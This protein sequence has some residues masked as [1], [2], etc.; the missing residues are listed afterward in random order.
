RNNLATKYAGGLH[1]G[2]GGADATLVRCRFVGN[3]S[4]G[5]AGGLFVLS[6]HAT[7]INSTFEGNTSFGAGALWSDLSTVTCTNC[8]FSGNAAVSGGGIALHHDDNLM[9]LTNC[10]FSRNTASDAG[11]GLLLQSGGPGGPSTVHFINSILWGNQDSGGTDESAQVLPASGS[12]TFDRTIVQGWTG[13]YGGTGN[14]GANP[15]FVDPDGADDVVGTDDDDLRLQAGSPAIDAGNTTTLPTD[16]YDLDGDGNTIERL[17]LDLGGNPRV[18]DDPTTADTGVPGSSVVD[19]GAY[20]YFPDC[21]HNGVADGCELDCGVANGPCDVPGCGLGADCNMNDILDACDIANC[22]GSPACDDCNLDGILDGC[23]VA[24]SAGCPG[25]G[26]VSGCLADIDQNCV[27]DVCV[28]PTGTG[29]TTNW[30]DDTNWNLAGSYPNNIS[31]GVPDLHVTLDHSLTLNLPVEIDSLIVLSGVALDVTGG[32]LT[33]TGAGG[34]TAGITIPPKLR[35]AGS[36]LLSS[37]LAVAVPNNA[38]VI[39]PGGVLAKQ[40]SAG[41]TSASVTATD[42]TVES[43]P[44][45]PGT[46][47]G[48]LGLTDSMSVVATGAITVHGL[49]PSCPYLDC[50]PSPDAVASVLGITLPPKLRVR[51]NAYANLLGTCSMTGAV[52][53]IIDSTEPV[54]L[55]GDFDN[56]S[57]VPSLFQCEAGKFTLTGATPQT[58][59][60]AGINLGQT[61]DGFSTNADALFDN[62]PPA[63]HHTNFSIGTL[64]AASGA[65]VTFVNRFANTVGV[66]CGEALY[67]SDLILRSGSTVTVD[68]CKVYYASLT[69]E[70]VTPTFI[71]CGELLPTTPPPAI[72]WNADPLSPDRNTRSLRFRV[73]AA[74]T[75][76]AAAAEGENAVKVTMVDLQNPVPSNAVCCPPKDFSAYEYGAS[77]TD[78]GG[79]AR[80][81]GEPGTF[82]EAQGPPLSGPYRAAR[83]QC[84]PFYADWVAETASGPITVV[85]A[86]I[87]PSSEYSVQTYGASCGGNENTCTNVSAPVT[88]YTRRSG[89]VETGYNPPGTGQQPDAGDVTALVNK[90]KK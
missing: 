81:V 25:G 34:Q 30:S 59:E 80:W 50:S 41:A 14:S 87:M 8:L 27:P 23:Q 61:T 49:D 19:M 1:I 12:V 4:F 72:T 21:N 43:G 65:N 11:G 55:G 75:A 32:N 83:L 88:M 2:A 7:V 74:A 28:A 73:A 69:D 42:V 56:R 9:T 77:C 17:S 5:T 90:F 54:E 67:V 24:S 66:G 78:P 62:C 46:A 64:E 39:E 89:D 86:E 76:T 31:G 44:C 58:F 16:T 22:G 18:L 79:C 13:S 10:T 68:N 20:E 85:G 84:S 52:D 36:I 45:Q 48:V 37:T 40:P 38:M 26:C 82:Y 47:G 60:V 15:L 71:G 3:R 51:N 33:I 29:G 63:Q 35:L 53:V 70:G 57:V 6:S